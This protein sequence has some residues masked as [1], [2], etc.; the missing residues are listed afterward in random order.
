MIRTGQSAG[1]AIEDVGIT[2]D[3]RHE[4]T[5]TDVLGGNT[6]LTEFCTQLLTTR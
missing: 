5:K 6:D 4:M 1:L 2:G 3:D